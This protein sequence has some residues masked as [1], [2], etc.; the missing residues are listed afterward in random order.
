[1]NWKPGFAVLT[2]VTLTGAAPATMAQAWPSKSVRIIVGFPAGGGTDPLARILAQKLSEAWGQPVVVENRPGASATLG[3]AAVAKATPDGYTLSMGQVT[4]NAIAPALFSK[5]PYAPKDLIPIVLVGTSPNVLVANPAVPVR[6]VAELV[7][8]ARSKPGK[9]TYGSSGAGSLQ[10]L[11]AESFI[12]LSGV[13]IVHVAYKGSGQAMVDLLGG[14]IDI[15]FDSMPGVIQQVKAGKL[16]ALAVT[17]AQRSSALPTVP[18]IA[19]GGYPEYDLTTW[20]GFFAPAGT[21]PEVLDKVHR[22]T[23][24]ALRSPDVR[25]RFNELSVTPG[26]GSSKE[27]ADYV[28]KEILKYDSL[29]KRLGVKL[30]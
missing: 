16:R 12:A 17:S 10:H 15:N 24:T 26:G 27:F 30:E 3:S 23:L 21:P 18:T 8:L 6:S 5:L 2:A 11:A 7:T 22:D 1:M 19:E 29:I 20:W 14:Q 13:N 4:P 28:Q 25:E 9:I